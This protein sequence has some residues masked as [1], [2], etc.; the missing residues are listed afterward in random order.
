MAST[1]SL[2]G[3]IVGSSINLFKRFKLGNMVEVCPIESLINFLNTI[4]NCLSCLSYFDD[5]LN[6]DFNLKEFMKIAF[7]LI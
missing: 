1:I 6:F 5:F 4:S 2:L 3:F 7:D